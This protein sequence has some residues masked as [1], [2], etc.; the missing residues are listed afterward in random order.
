MMQFNT[1][2]KCIILNKPFIGGYIDQSNENEAHE[3]INF[4]LDD[5]GNH[6]IYCNPY[7][8]NVRDAA[9]KQVEYVLFTSS[10][11]AGCFYI[12]Y[13]VEIGATLHSQSLPKPTDRNRKT[14]DSKICDAM[15]EIEENIK[16]LGYK[17]IEDIQYGGISLNN[18][19]TDSIQVIP[20]TFLAENIYRLKNPIKIEGN[21]EIF[22]YN[23]QRN[24]GYVTSESKSPKAYKELKEK[25]KATIDQQQVNKL[26]VKK[27]NLNGLKGRYSQAIPTFMD[28][29]SMYRQE[30]CYTQILYK[31]FNYRKE[32]IH[33]FLHEIGIEANNNDTDKD[34]HIENE[35]VIKNVGRLDLFIYNDNYNIIIEN[36]IDSG[37][38]YVSKDKEK[39]DQLTRYYKYFEDSEHKGIQKNIY[40]IFAP[41]E[42]TTFIKAEIKSIGNDKVATAFKIIEY[43]QIYEF[44]KKN[45]NEYSNFEYIGQFNNILEVFRRLS[46]TRQEMCEENLLQNIYKIRHIS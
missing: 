23:F 25:I 35:Y 46:L 22:D 17:T 24:F 1:E 40:L 10:A 44:F 15:S 16:N 45:E 30:E 39:T 6:F 11:K 21:S 43:K 7:G 2:E 20:L 13:I 37:I 28:L 12:E 42:K 4:F 32:L 27:F 5:K 31:L 9:D 8:Q 18:L 26:T 33:R 38:N 29:I 34:W 36:K 14:I 3:L 41:N 19:F